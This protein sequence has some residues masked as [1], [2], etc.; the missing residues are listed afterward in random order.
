MNSRGGYESS[1]TGDSN[2]CPEKTHHSGEEL[3]AALC[4][5]NWSSRSSQ[6][7]LRTTITWIASA[8]CPS[9]CQTQTFSF[10]GWGQGPGHEHLLKVSLAIQVCSSGSRP[11]L[12]QVMYFHLHQTQL[13]DCYSARF[14][15]SFQNSQMRFL[16]VGSEDMCVF[17]VVFPSCSDVP[18]AYLSLRPI[19]LSS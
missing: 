1:V 9:P 8:R 3:S 16:C 2:K 6:I 17:V 18:Y 4:L 11:P 7:R 13:E 19:S 12:Q 10:I 14:L 5:Y 15:D